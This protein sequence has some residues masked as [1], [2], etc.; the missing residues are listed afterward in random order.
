VNRALAGKFEQATWLVAEIGH[1]RDWWAVPRHPFHE[2]WSAGRL[3]A[4]ELQTYAGEH[5]HVA[6]ALADVSRRAAMLAEEMLHE[7]L[8]GHWADREREVELWCEFAAATGWSPQSAWC[9]AAD[10][11]PE[12]VAGAQAWTGDAERSLAEHLVT[13][14]ALETAQAE[15]ARPL[16]GALL[17]Q[18]GFAD[19]GSTRYFALRCRGDAGA[20][21]LLEA[22]LTGLLPV[23]DP[24]SLVRRA[25]LTYRAYWELL[26]GVDRFAQ[27]GGF[28][29][30]ATGAGASGSAPGARSGAPPPGGPP[31][32]AAH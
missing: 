28:T 24:F 9:Y 4:A 19:D 14:Y 8:A 11:L 16:L 22:A 5:H 6:V 12:T 1:R 26:D 17:G 10:P 13:M 3:T 2:R 31:G 15:V 32:Q 27:N 7:Q 23:P 21:G 29:G 30:L 18:Y 25:E 20:A